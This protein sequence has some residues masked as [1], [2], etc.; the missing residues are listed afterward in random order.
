MKRPAIFIDRDG[1]INEQ[2]GYINHPSRFIILPGVPEAFRLLNRAGFLALIVSNQS[3]VARGYFPIEL[4]YNIH[5]KMKEP[6]TRQGGHIDGIYFC[7]HYPRGSVSEYAVEC[8][9]RK[10]RTGLIDRA[11]KDFEID[12][13]RSYMIGDHYTDMELADRAGIKGILVRTGYGAGVIEY[14][15]PVMATKPAYIA[16]DLLDAVKWIIERDM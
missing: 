10:P 4:I 14:N 13:T 9:C 8:D 6:I 7:P 15:L 3:G 16:D 12:L 5:D 11:C 1:T 2:R